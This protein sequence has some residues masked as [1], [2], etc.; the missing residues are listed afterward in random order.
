MKQII[1]CPV[2]ECLQQS[3]KTAQQHSKSGNENWWNC[4]NTTISLEKI[5]LHLR[6]RTVLCEADETTKR[7]WDSQ[8]NVGSKVISSYIRNSVFITS[9]IKKNHIL[10]IRKRRYVYTNREIGFSMDSTSNSTENTKNQ[11]HLAK[12]WDERMK[13]RQ[14]TKYHQPKI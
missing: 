9:D 11:C 2:Q 8:V 12:Y 10:V 4:F 14:A 7:R 13:W 3:K 6:R 5:C 1:K